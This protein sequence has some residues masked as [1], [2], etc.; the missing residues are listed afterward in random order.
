MSFDLGVFVSD[1]A[2]IKSFGEM[3]RNLGLSG[4]AISSSNSDTYWSLSENL[5]AYRRVILHGKGINS[6]RKQISNIR[7]KTV[8]VSV[9]LKSIDIAN[10]AIEDNRIDLLTVDP[11]QENR[12]R[13][14][15]ARL[16]SASNTC[17]EI[18][19]APLL[20][21]IGLNRSK[22]LKSYREAVSTARDAGMDVVV[23]SGATHPMGLR[24]SVSMVHIGIL[25]GMDRAYAESS[26]RTIPMS[27]IERNMK[28]LQPEFVSDGIEILQ[29]EERK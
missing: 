26:V 3:A 14:S 7:R 13:D 8:I 2:N 24:S 1:I 21:T 5:T 10:W 17:L 9:D 15:T 28:K 4:I 20:K 25:L 6:V 23:T 18:Q 16:A 19:I 12:L 27:I 11:N 22:V 29:K